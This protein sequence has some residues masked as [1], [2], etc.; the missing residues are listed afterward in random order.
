[1]KF[2]LFQDGNV[3]VCLE[4][5]SQDVEPASKQVSTSALFFEVM[6]LML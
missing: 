5:F 3:I 1:M 4:V 6:Q 2:P